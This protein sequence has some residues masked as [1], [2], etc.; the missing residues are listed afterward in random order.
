MTAPSNMAIEHLASWVQ[1]AQHLTYTRTELPQLRL[2]TT[3]VGRE[4]ACLG[5]KT[6][7]LPVLKLTAFIGKPVEC[8][9]LESM[10]E[11]GC[12]QHRLALQCI[13][14]KEPRLSS[15]A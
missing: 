11:S 4:R 5:C 13:L 14:G 6:A 8:F 12:M 3:E 7:F 1:L 10:T 15:V 9:P 2:S